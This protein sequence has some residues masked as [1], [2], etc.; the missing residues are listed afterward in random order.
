MAPFLSRNNM[1]CF[2]MCGQNHLAQNTADVFHHGIHAM[3]KE[4]MELKHFEAYFSTTVWHKRRAA[5]HSTH[6]Q[7][8]A[9]CSMDGNI[10]VCT[11]LANT[12]IHFFICLRT[13]VSLRLPS[14]GEN[15]K[16]RFTC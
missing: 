3:C 10:K 12:G 4:I 8:R 13:V 5:F 11:N 2:C 16:Q 6:A 1:N 14:H 7:V 9:E 15:L